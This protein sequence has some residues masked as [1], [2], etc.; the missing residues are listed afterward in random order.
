MIGSASTKYAL[1]SLLR[2]TRRTILSAVGIGI[3]CGMGMV[4]SSWVRGAGEMQIRAVAESG[5]GHLR[6]VPKGWT[7]RRDNNLRLA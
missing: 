6:V 2:N 4:A 7:E 5:G 3:G 1:R